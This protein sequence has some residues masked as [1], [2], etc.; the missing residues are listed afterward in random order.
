MLLLY[1][2]NYSGFVLCN[3]QGGEP[4]IGLP[5]FLAYPF[6]DPILGQ[7]FPFR[8]MSMIISLMSHVI[9]SIIARWIFVNNL[10]P[11]KWDLLR[12]FN[13][14]IIPGTVPALA[15]RPTVPVSTISQSSDLRKKSHDDSV[16]G[17]CSSLDMGR[18]YIPRPKLRRNSGHGIYRREIVPGYSQGELRNHWYFYH[19]FNVSFIKNTSLYGWQSTGLIF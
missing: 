18:L 15:I 12:C 6:Y 16:S 8:T 13:Q 10:L 4:L 2:I 1:F 9:V 14:P 19:C 7:L 5:A 3:F 11:A 17:Q